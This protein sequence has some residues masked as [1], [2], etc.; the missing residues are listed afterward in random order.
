MGD[1]K[2]KGRLPV[3]EGMKNLKETMTGKMIIFK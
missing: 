2:S 3:I 1:P